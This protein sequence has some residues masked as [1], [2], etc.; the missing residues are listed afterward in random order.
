MHI[1]VFLFSEKG[2]ERITY[3]TFAIVFTLNLVYILG[4]LHMS[5]IFSTSFD[6]MDIFS[7]FETFNF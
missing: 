1:R 5:I 4:S 2:T 6:V 7:V 3:F